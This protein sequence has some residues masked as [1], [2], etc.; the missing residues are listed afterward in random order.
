MKFTILPTI[1][2]DLSKAQEMDLGWGEVVEA[3][4]LR[5]DPALTDKKSLP[6][7]LPGAFKKGEKRRVDDAVES[8]TLAVLDFDNVTQ[9]EL[10]TLLDQVKGLRHCTYTTWSNRKHQEQTGNWKFRLVLPFSRPVTPEEWPAVWEGVYRLL[11]SI[12]DDKGVSKGFADKSCKN[13]G[14]IYY[15]PYLDYPGQD[16][17]FEHDF[18]TS[19]DGPSLDVDTF[20]ANYQVEK[21]QKEVPA[22]AG[23]FVFHIDQLNPIIKKLAKSESGVHAQVAAWL[24]K[25]VKGDP[26]PFPVGQRHESYKLICKIL[27]DHFFNVDTNHLY[28]TTLARS[29]IQLNQETPE[30]PIEDQ[31]VI[32]LL[33]GA[34]EKYREVLE[35]RKEERDATEIEDCKLVGVKEPYTREQV[36]EWAAKM[37]LTFE[38]LKRRL[39]VGVGENFW[40]FF[41]GGYVETTKPVAQV[42]LHQLLAPAVRVFNLKMT[43]PTREDVVDKTPAALMKRYGVSSYKLR[44]DAG[45]TAFGFEDNRQTFLAPLFQRRDWQPMRSEFVEGWLTALCSNEPGKLEMLEKWLAWSVDLTQPLA[46]LFLSGAPGAGKTLF[47]TALSSLWECDFIE[48]DNVFTHF[49]GEMIQSPIILA[50]EGFP[51]DQTR[52][53]RSLLGRGYHKVEQKYREVSTIESNFR[54]VVTANN[55]ASFFNLR[56]EVLGA[57][58]LEALAIRTFHV[59]ASEDASE[60]L[61][62]AEFTRIGEML[63]GEFAMHVMWLAEK[64]KDA[65][66][67]RFGTKPDS[68][69]VRKI[70]V[71][72][73]VPSQLMR[74]VIGYLTSDKIEKKRASAAKVRV[75]KENLLLTVRAFEDWDCYLNEP[76]P[77]FDAILQAFGTI[78]TSKER[79]KLIPGAQDAGKQELVSYSV[80]SLAHL[81]AWVEAHPTYVSWE[82]LRLAL[83]RDTPINWSKPLGA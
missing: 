42:S 79:K 75:S 39:I 30:D 56:K 7:F 45:R 51:P 36:D 41:K 27:G 57:F 70:T 53:I 47:A 32:N 3:L 72:S 2:S 69:M 77:A 9:V 60:Y 20:L 67:S 6:L 40:V 19:E 4:A 64:Y 43:T 33:S 54:F 13:V 71:S 22:V 23:S 16:G 50:D 5:H 1:T 17:Q 12:E 21:N 65:T 62:K 8:L 25:I 37:G 15:L 18:A 31:D 46:L 55:E 58:D 68:K 26:L 10:I 44:Y 49:N 38:E 11:G 14:R 52:R 80:L 73:G 82:E 59:E 29:V 61:E 66:R 83:S 78:T 63:K 34:Q 81:E 48:S 35:K 28:K 76:K 74:W 24:K